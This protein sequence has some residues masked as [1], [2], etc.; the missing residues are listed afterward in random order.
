MNYFASDNTSEIHK[1]ILNSIININKGNEPSY[2]SDQYTIQTINKFK[3]ILKNEEIG[4]FF[5]STGSAV[6]ILGFSSIVN[7]FESIIC[8][9]HSHSLNHT[10]GGPE[11]YIGCR[12]KVIPSIDGKIYPDQIETI[13]KESLNDNHVN[14]PK[15][16]SITQPTEFGLVYTL[17]EIQSISKVC[18]ENNLY[19]HMDGSRLSNALVQLQT[20]LYEVSKGVDLLHFGG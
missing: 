7:S 18:K 3:K 5:F 14:K 1:K 15:V 12:L 13:V 11:N 19:L 10:T 4:V 16:V 6:N 9:S 2:G 8:S 20:S 17:E